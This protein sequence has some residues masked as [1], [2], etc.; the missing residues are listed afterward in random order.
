MIGCCYISSIATLLISDFILGLGHMGSKM[1]SNISSDGNNLVVYD[2]N[3]ETAQS[4]AS[5]SVRPVVSAYSYCARVALS[6]FFF[7]ENH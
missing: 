4:L 5:A 7:S 6:F 1:V 3:A 2:A